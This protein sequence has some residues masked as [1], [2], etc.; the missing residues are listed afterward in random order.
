MFQE[1]YGRRERRDPANGNVFYSYDVKAEAMPSQN[2]LMCNVSSTGACI[3]T[4]ECF[5]EGSELKLFSPAIGLPKKAVVRW[6]KSVDAKLFKMG[7]SFVY[8]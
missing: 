4:Q 7:L 6:C 5:N 1:S 3:Y 2:G 8:A